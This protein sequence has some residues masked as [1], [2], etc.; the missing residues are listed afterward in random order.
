MKKLISILIAT[1]I[2]SLAGFSPQGAADC[3]GKN[4]P[5]KMH[6]RGEGHEKE[7][8]ACP[9]VDKL[10]RKGHFYLENQEALGLSEEQVAQIK[11]IKLEA[12]K[13]YIRQMGEFQIARLEMGYQLS[14]TNPDTKGV[15]DLIDQQAASMAQ[16]AKASV[17][18]LLKLKSVLTEEQRVKAKEL[19][20][21]DRDR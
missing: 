18:E 7:K 16:G 9:I 1:F 19:L 5:L 20:D 6:G 17:A 8:Y 4:C 2:F 10:M 15:N 13:D 21:S 14:Q 11:Q 3:G 12:K